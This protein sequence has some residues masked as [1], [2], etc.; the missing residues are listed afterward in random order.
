MR[1]PRL[2]SAFLVL[3]AVAAQSLTAAAD[4]AR[5]SPAEQRKGDVMAVTAGGAIY[6]FVGLLAGVTVGA[7]LGRNTLLELD[8]YRAA[9]V[10][11]E[12]SSASAALRVQQFVTATLY[13][14]AGARLR[15]VRFSEDTELEFQTFR[16]ST[17]Q[18]DVGFDLAFGNR[19]QWGHL[20]VGV[21]WAGIYLP[22]AAL[23]TEERIEAMDN[24]EILSVERTDRRGRPDIRLLGVQVGASF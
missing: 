3:L 13:L 8:G 17:L 6:E 10:L 20:I 12:Q 18:D 21:D 1:P 16:R 22:L 9:S 23:A 7:Y 15:R 11:P 4:P 14:R 5:P 2:P 19:W 24:G